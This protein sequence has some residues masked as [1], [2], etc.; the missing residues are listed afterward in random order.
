MNP[1]L[2]GQV[3]LDSFVYVFDDKKNVAGW[4]QKRIAADLE[5]GREF[6]E[7]GSYLVDDASSWPPGSTLPKC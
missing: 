4:S 6:L 2:P 7:T 1:A 5:K 3:L